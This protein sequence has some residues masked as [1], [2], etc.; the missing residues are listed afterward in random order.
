MKTFW[1][2]SPFLSILACLFFSFQVKED[3]NY[4]R[5]IDAWHEKR[6]AS[7]K[8][9]TGWLNLAGLFWLKEGKN[10]FGSEEDN[11][12]VFPEGK[13]ALE[14]GSLVLENGRVTLF[15]FDSTVKV[16]HA[17]GR[18]QLLYPYKDEKDPIVAESGSLKWFVIKRGEKYA[19]RLRDLESPVLKEFKGID[20]FP[21]QAEWRVTAWM[22]K[23]PSPM[24]IPITD[25]TGLTTLTSVPGTLSFVLQGQTCRLLP[26]KENGKLF[27]VFADQSNGDETYPSGRFLYADW[28]D[29][30][31]MTV[32]DFNKSYNP[33]CAF[34]SFATCPLP[35]SQNF[36]SLKVTAGEKTWHG[37]QH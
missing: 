20:R 27:L 8:S 25:V 12:L 28:P 5:E 34:T 15:V 10:T 31:G 11:D 24:A 1:K 33:P 2:H 37:N 7:L 3:V 4:Q 36:L 32:L 18:E 26:T 6:I 23:S 14:A 9:E 35:P 16:Q 21:V 29:S 13:I 19:V 30:T 17:K 22:E